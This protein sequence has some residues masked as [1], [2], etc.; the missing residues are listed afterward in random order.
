VKRFFVGLVVLANLAPV[1]VIAEE[2]QMAGRNPLHESSIEQGP[3]APLREAWH[4][5]S[6][7]PESSFTTWPVAK[8]GVVYASSGPGVIA[9]DA[10]TGARRWF[11][12]PEEGQ[13][14]VAPA[15]EGGSLQ[16]PLPF[17][18]ILALAV[19]SGKELW[20]FQADDDLDASPTLADGRLYFGSTFGK[21]FYSVDASSGRL[22]WTVSTGD[23]YADSV[24]AVSQGM[25]VFSIQHSETSK[26]NL[27]ALAADTGAELWRV[28]QEEANSSPSILGSSVVFGGG[29]FF[30]YALDLKT[31]Q[32]IWKSPVE[33]KFGVRNMPA[34]AFGDVFLADRIGNIY[35]LDGQT[36]KRE[37]IFKDTEGAMDQSFPVIAGKT[38][39]IGSDAGFLYAL[40]ADSGRLLWKDQVQGIVLSGAADAER[41]YFGVKFGDEGLY[42]Y[43]HDPEG[44]LEPP[45][46]AGFRPP[47]GL[48]TSLLVFLLLFG[49]FLFYA[50]RR[51]SRA[52]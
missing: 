7:D 12:A 24:P 44:K 49:G 35:R 42:A 18:R 16:I 17:G 31:G 9:V 1:N 3:I 26:V 45:P 32:E 11:V 13:T 4:V 20:R 41:F 10:R 28:E 34:I 51:R 50:R 5:K 2:W 52:A 48:L 39:F 27:L 37:W 38:L 8:N 47:T 36:G 19:D 30:A 43:E 33:D 29:D 46:P 6:P 14:Q 40:D 23:F 15:L 21:Q 22:A 25:V